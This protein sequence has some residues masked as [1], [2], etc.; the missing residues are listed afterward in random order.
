[1]SSGMEL[2]HFF[3]TLVAIVQRFSTIHSHQ[4]G[5]ADPA[6]VSTLASDN[7][8][9]LS[10]VTGDTMGRV[11]VYW[12]PLRSLQEFRASKSS[13]TR[14]VLQ[15]TSNSL[16]CGYWISNLAIRWPDR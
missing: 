13:S 3:L 11:G 1:M 12:K 2:T 7:R 14:L 10:G 8:L 6:T 4:S 16:R 15:N 9:Q 5:N